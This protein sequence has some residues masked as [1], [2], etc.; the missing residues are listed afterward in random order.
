MNLSMVNR[1]KLNIPGLGK[2][3]AC[4]SVDAQHIEAFTVTHSVEFVI[5]AEHKGIF[6]DDLPNIGKVHIIE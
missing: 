5:P 1:T 2:D 4:V 3:P 6:G